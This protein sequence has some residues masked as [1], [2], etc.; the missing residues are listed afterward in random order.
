MTCLKNNN[1][2]QLNNATVEASKSSFPFLTVLGLLFIALKLMNYITWHWIWV[3]SPF[4]MPIAIVFGI[5]V[6]AIIVCLLVILAISLYEL[7]KGE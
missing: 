2:N 7:Y 5:Y 6:V 1:L 4:W 3:L